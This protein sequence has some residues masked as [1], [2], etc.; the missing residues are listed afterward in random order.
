MTKHEHTT[1][2]KGRD[3]PFLLVGILGIG[4]SGPLV[5]KSAMPIPTLIFWRNLG[6]A[7]IM[8]PFALKN[9]EWR[10]KS[11]RRA[12]GLSALAGA[13]LGAHF[14]VFFAAMR[15]T[16]VATGTAL[17]AMQPLFAAIYM[18]FRGASISFRSF[19]G[20]LIAFFS[21]FLVTSIDFTISTRAF[22]GDLFGI[23]CGA[24]AAAYVIIGSQVQKSLS[25]S[26]YTTVCYAACAF[27][28]LLATAVTGS[29]LFHFATAQWI[30][31][32]EL[33]LGAQLLGHTLFNLTLKRVSPVVVSLI[34]FFEVPVAAIIAWLWLHQKP[35]VGTWPGIIGLLIGCAIFVA[36]PKKI[37]G[38]PDQLR[39]ARND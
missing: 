9:G 30:Y 16:S 37:E 4:S 32:G 33:L 29:T 21:L 14:L 25:T 24:L 19:V 7:M 20:M 18:K 35:A 15:F 23:S 27:T 39:G 38:I 2:P 6:G 3:I 31:V 17:A 8:A 12:L 5:A 34:V 13:L 11:N 10:E 22:V 36:P 1:L 26:T 28:G